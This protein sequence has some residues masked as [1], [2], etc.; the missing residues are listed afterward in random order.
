MMHDRSEKRMTIS[1]RVDLSKELIKKHIY[2]DFDIL[3]A[4]NSMF[5]KG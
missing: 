2:D 3:E 5:N 1:I 4:Q